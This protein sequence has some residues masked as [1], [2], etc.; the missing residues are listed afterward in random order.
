[1]FDDDDDDDDSLFMAAENIS[2]TEE[3][4]I[5]DVAFIMNE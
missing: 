3:A 4:L 5:S 1:V 2:E